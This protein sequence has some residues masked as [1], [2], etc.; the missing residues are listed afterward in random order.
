MRARLSTLT[1][2]SSRKKVYFEM[3]KHLSLENTACLRDLTGRAPRAPHLR[4][5]EA[6]LF[7]LDG[8]KRMTNLRSCSQLERE[9]NTLSSNTKFYLSIQV[10]RSSDLRSSFC[11]SWSSDPCLSRFRFLIKYRKNYPTHEAAELK[12]NIN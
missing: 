1:F 3:I 11:P 6:I 7:L 4:W 10:S 9:R 12:E 5:V 8:S 2:L